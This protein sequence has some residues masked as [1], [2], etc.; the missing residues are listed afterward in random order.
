MT[1]A[2]ESA[3]DGGAGNRG[4]RG[5]PRD[6][7]VDTAIMSAAVE[8]L[9]EVGFSHLTMEQVASRA[10]VSKASLYLRW[11]GKVAVVAEAIRRHSA[12]VPEVPD[13]GNLHEDMLAFL[14]ALVQG[15][16]DAARALAAVTGEIASN[17][18][19]RTAWRAGV[20]GAVTGS[21]RIIIERALQR[22]EL[23]KDTDVELLTMLP[24]TLLQSW[25]LHHEH[26]P[27]DLLIQRIADQFYPRA[28]ALQPTRLTDEKARHGTRS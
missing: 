21:I 14:R 16:Q 20:S 3:P 13:T 5:R 28:D 6:P 9:G 7:D 8:L 4:T 23:P 24:L 22:E 18:E 11:Q 19:L 25:R 26:G 2:E 12:I 1:D 10:R 15:K 27:D 17:P